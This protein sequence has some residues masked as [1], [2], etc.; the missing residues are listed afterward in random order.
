MILS[1]QPLAASTFE[2][3]LH[4]YEKGDHNT[5]FQV[6]KAVAEAGD[7]RAF[8]KLAGLYLYG[9]GTKKDYRQA[10]LWFGIS[11]ASGDPYA[12]DFQRAASSMLEPD[13]VRKLQPLID[14]KITQLGLGS[15]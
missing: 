9:Q 13:D 2:E 10:Y 4:A 3:A 14:E 6:F 1:S 15:L 7:K 11:A 5:A 12:K 8:G